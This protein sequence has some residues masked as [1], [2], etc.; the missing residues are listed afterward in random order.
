M[1]IVRLALR[2]PY[3]FVVLAILILI[4]GITVILR[5]PTDI[6]PDVDIPVVTVLWNYTGLSPEEMAARISSKFERGVSTTVSNIEHIES[7]NLAGRSVVKIYFQPGTNVDAGVA[8]VTAIAQAEIHSLPLGTLPPLIITFDASSVP[9]LELALSGNG[10]SEQALFDVANSFLRTQLA[11]VRG[12]AI[13]WPYGGKQNQVQVDI[14]STKLQAMHL[15]PADVVNA[16]SVQ[17]LILPSGTEKIGHYEYQV[18]TNSAPRTIEELNNLPIK[19]VNGAT[20]YVRDVAHVRN[21]FSPQTNIVRVNGR[22]AALMVI[23]KTGKVSTLNLVADVR[24][25]LPRVET[26]LP[27]QLKIRPMDDQSIFCLLYTSPSPRDRQK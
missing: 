5:T 7:E 27:P 26:T 14:D 21:G 1:W 15:S 8:Q 24:S 3:T 6:F 11:T 20:I 12:A 19:T 25:I 13:P 18:E 17:N 22:R 9:V 4:L 2:R 10:L 23:R 16:F